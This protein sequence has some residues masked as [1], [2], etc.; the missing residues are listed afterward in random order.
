MTVCAQ[1]RFFIG[2]LSMRE[3]LALEAEVSSKKK[4]GNKE[5]KEWLISLAIVLL[6]AFVLRYFAIGTLV[7]KGISME[8]TFYQWQCYS[9]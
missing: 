5:I 3:F 7:V 2:L 4:N 1:A 9:C 6:V 8:P